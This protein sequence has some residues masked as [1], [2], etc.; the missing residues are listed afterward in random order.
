MLADVAAADGAQKGVGQG[1]QAG[2]GVRM[3]DQ[4]PVVR[5]VD[6]TEPDGVPGAE[7]MGVQPL[8]DAREAGLAA[9]ASAIAKS[10]G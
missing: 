6:P 5:D 8:A 2:V 1:V 3:A 9:K 4:A 7:A 10:S